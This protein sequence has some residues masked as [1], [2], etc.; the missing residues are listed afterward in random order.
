VTPLRLSS[1]LLRWLFVWTFLA[2]FTVLVPFVPSPAAASIPRQI[3]IESSYDPEVE[4]LE[5]ATRINGARTWRIHGPDLSGSFGAL[6][7]IGGLEPTIRE[8]GNQVTALIND[9]YGHAAATIEQGSGALT[10]NAVRSSDRRPLRVICAAQLIACMIERYFNFCD[11]LPKTD[12]LVAVPLGIQSKKALLEILGCGLRFPDYFGSNWDAFEEC[13]R[14]LSWLPNGN[15]TIR[16]HDVPLIGD[17]SGAKTY[18]LILRDAV[19]KWQ[20]ST[21]HHLIVSFPL[22]DK[23]AVER[24]LET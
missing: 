23:S 24:L 16:H 11:M 1:R 12:G 22:G 20:T 14:D 17:P 15:L 13:L 5:V 9:V 2:G 8:S 6:Q 10:W 3:L 18:L 21:E 4:F 19:K 7:G